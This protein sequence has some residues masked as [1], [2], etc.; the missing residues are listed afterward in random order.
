M[1]VWLLISLSATPRIY[2]P[3]VPGIMS[4]KFEPKAP[5]NLDP[6]KDDPISPEELAK[7]NGTSDLPLQPVK[8][9]TS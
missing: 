1:A 3:I 2:S 5:V 7:A 8:P 4:G 6:P 9:A